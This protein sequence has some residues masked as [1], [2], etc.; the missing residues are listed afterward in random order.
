MIHKT[1]KEMNQ[2][3]FADIHTYKVYAHTINVNHYIVKGKDKDEAKEKVLQL[4]KGKSKMVMKPTFDRS[5]IR[6]KK[7]ERIADERET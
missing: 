2:N 3:K 4:C 1:M 6:I 5:Y 7:I